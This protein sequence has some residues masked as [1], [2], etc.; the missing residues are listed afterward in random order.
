MNIDN[1]SIRE[2]PPSEK[3]MRNEVLLSMVE[4]D[5]LQMLAQA[6][7]PEA[8]K[9][10]HSHNNNKKRRSLRRMQNESRRRNR[11]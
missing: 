9:E 5:Y 11:K 1:G 6:E 8:Y 2:I 3:P 7:R 4:A 10:L